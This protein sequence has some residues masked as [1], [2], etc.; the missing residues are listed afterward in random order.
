MAKI[1][2]VD[3]SAFMRKILVGVLAKAGYT[4]IAEASDGEMAV[5]SYKSQKP[6]LV[7]L[8]VVMAPKDGLY[9]LKEIR[10]K[11][12][13][14]KVIMVTAVGQEAMIADAKKLGCSEYVVKPFKE[15]QVIAA[16]K[17]ALGKK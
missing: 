16:V 5:A 2:V 12:S 1:L 13:S 4:D 7:L 3:D 6:D 9:A 11:S 10:A 15:E 8:D 14:A 17:A